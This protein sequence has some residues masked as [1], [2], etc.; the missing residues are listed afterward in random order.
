[1]QRPQMGLD[2]YWCRYNN[3]DSFEQTLGTD[4]RY[5]F[6]SGMN[7]CTFGVGSQAGNGV[8]RVCHVNAQYQKGREDRAEQRVITLDETNAR[9]EQIQRNIAGGVLYK[10]NPQNAVIDRRTQI[11]EPSA[12]M[13]KQ[14]NGIVVNWYWSATT[15]GVRGNDNYWRFYFLRWKRNGN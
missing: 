12:Y 13:T 4:S 1:P 14:G 5:V 15:F 10:T 6:T 3:N 9:Q 8:C 2:I 11:L 7:M